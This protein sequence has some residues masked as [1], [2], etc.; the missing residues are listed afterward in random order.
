MGPP[1]GIGSG[2]FCINWQKRLYFTRTH[3]RGGDC[4]DIGGERLLKGNGVFIGCFS[5]PVLG[6]LFQKNQVIRPSE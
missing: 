3:D 4:R 2:C 6:P 5:T 1:I